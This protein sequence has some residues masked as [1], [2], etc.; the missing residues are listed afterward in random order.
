M[1]WM[2]WFF[3]ADRRF[4]RLLARQAEVAV[5]A[6]AVLAAQGTPAEMARVE[7][8]GD[9][10]RRELGA[11]LARTY[12]TPFD[13]D[14]IFELSSALDDV[15]DAAQE[16]LSSLAVFGG[17]GYAHVQEMCGSLQEGAR[18][19]SAAVALLPAA[20]AREPSRRAKRSENVVGNLY[21][22]GLELAVRTRPAE[23][24]LRLREVLADL[25]ELS[26]AIGRA[27]D[28]VT[29]VTVKEK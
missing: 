23:E 27:A 9:A 11:A 22:Y 28:L 17:G 15:A 8:A 20:A 2:D 25:R 18:A 3:P 21:R 26:R 16:A 5:Q 24:A 6:C 10:L 7:A 4:G 29:D 14:D 1:S 19:L 13:R 12:A